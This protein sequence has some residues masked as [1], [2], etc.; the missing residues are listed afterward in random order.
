MDKKMDKKYFELIPAS[1]LPTRDDW[2]PIVNDNGSLEI[3]QF[4]NGQWLKYESPEYP[5]WYPTSSTAFSYLRQATVLEEMWR[6]P[7]QLPQVVN[8][9][10]SQVL[11][12][13]IKGKRTFHTV[14]YY[15]PDKF[16]TV[17]WED[18]DDYDQQDYPYT[19]EDAEAGCV[20]LNAGW[21][22][23][24][25]CDK[26]DGYWSAPLTVVSWMPIP[27]E[28]TPSRIA[29]LENELADL[30]LWKKQAIEAMP[31]YQAI[32]EA[33]GLQ[34]G[35]TISNKIIPFIENLKADIARWKEEA[36][37]TRSIKF[38]VRRLLLESKGE[39]INVDRLLSVIGI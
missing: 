1:T 10:M 2:Y 25:E 24:V 38:E 34:V 14:A 4:V 26:C 31:D 22:E 30:H 8:K 5:H 11:V 6:S 7:D 15:F 17:E 29:E 36:E 28:S 16:K 39:N 23:S 3:M 37:V 32:G 27:S 33:M 13:H 19:T 20:W 21:Y 35:Q 9:K 12:K 18:W